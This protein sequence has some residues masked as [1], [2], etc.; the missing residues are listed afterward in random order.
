MS[1]QGDV[2]T[3]AVTLGDPAGV[4][5]EVVMKA[6]AAGD[7]GCAI[8]LVG[9][10]WALRSGANVAGV[11]ADLLLARSWL[12]HRDIPVAE[13][14][15]FE[16]G[17]VDSACGQA[18]VQ[19]VEAAARGVLDG[20]YSAMVTAPINKESVHAAGYVDDIG[21]QEILA[22]IAGSSWTAT[23]LMTPGLR[24]AHLSTHLSLIEAAR[25]VTEPIVFDKLILLNDTLKGWGI[26]RPSIAVAALNPH[27]GE[28]GLLGREEIEEIGPAVVRAQTAG[29]DA[30]GP[31]PADSVFN[32][33]INGEFDVVLALYHDQGHIAIKVHDFHQST[34]ATMGLP[35]IRTS[36]DHGTA[37]DIAGSGTADPT[38]M[39]AALNM[40][41]T[42]LE[43]RLR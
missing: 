26:E 19:A 13:P 23:M 8:E 12:S 34:T 22:R 9:P 6:L 33:A 41:V 39:L 10:T 4:G 43:R 5:P 31:I 36:V 37:F 7:P 24:V 35:F 32:R 15:G 16:H 38:S 30:H 11:D 40:A 20:R 1:N 42:L 21:H 2:T 14:P 3:L 28:G 27:G 29:L 17:R 18:A 25:Y